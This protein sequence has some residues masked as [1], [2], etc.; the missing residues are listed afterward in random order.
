MS[1]LW[2]AHPPEY[3]CIGEKNLGNTKEFTIQCKIGEKTTTGEGTNK[4]LAKKLAA[5]AMLKI[6]LGEVRIKLCNVIFHTL[7]FILCYLTKD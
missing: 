2:I 6:V 3:A 1:K 5:E 4:K 7:A